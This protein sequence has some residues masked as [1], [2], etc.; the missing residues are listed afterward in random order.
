LDVVFTPS[1]LAGSGGHPPTFQKFILDTSA[2]LNAWGHISTYD[3]AEKPPSEKTT[4]FEG[5]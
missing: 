2:G 3:S 4:P 1:F 5:V